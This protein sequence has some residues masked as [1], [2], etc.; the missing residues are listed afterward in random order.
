MTRDEEGGRGGEDEEAREREGRRVE[1]E[2]GRRTM[3]ALWFR[4]A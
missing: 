3:T 2:P 4:I 1:M